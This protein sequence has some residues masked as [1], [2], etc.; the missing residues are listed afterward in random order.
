M[1]TVSLFPRLFAY[2]ESTNVCSNS[3]VDSFS[4]RKIDFSH[5]RASRKICDNST[6]NYVYLLPTQKIYL[7]LLDIKQNY[8]FSD[9]L[10][11][12]LM[13]VFVT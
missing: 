7:L 9:F 12:P 13:E 3:A 10:N 4:P 6:S 8:V 5:E 2:I 11:P 1:H